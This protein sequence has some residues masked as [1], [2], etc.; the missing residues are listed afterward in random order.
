MSSYSQ[1]IRKETFCITDS[2][3]GKK[4]VW[5][6]KVNRGLLLNISDKIYF[7]C[8]YK[9]FGVWHDAKFAINGSA[10]NHIGKMGKFKTRKV[11]DFICQTGSKHTLADVIMYGLNLSPDWENGIKK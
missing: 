1:E 5:P 6:F 2:E 8:R 9:R 7:A 10:I 3:T 11:P 4:R